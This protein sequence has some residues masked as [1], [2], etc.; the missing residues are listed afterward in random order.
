[1]AWQ[2]KARTMS[3]AFSAAGPGLKS[4]TPTVA[5]TGR[6]SNALKEFL[7]L[8]SDIPKAKLLDMGQVSQDTLNF[9]IEKG[10]RV[11]TE[12]FLRSWRDFMDAEEARLRG[13]KIGADEERP[14][15]AILA[16][17][18][19]EDLLKYPPESFNG[20]LAW[21]LFDYMEPEM[22]ARAVARLHDILRP[23]GV[24][25]AIFHSRT[26]DRFC[27]YRVLPDQTFELLPLP[28]I[29]QH[30]HIFQNREML[31]LFA[32]FRTSKTFVGRDQLREG[33]FLK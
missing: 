29:A 12:D 5:S 8:L 15:P 31:D 7:W 32:K 23:G 17:R 19:L 14:S 6:V 21:D 3:P 4:V 27:R 28:P 11:T 16:D 25:L 30:V 13:G 10:F 33:L 20:I 9:F 18:F 2:M 26:P 24:V 1:M 22:L